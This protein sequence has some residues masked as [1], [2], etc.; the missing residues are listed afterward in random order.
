MDVKTINKLFNIF[1]FIIKI[2]NVRLKI[3]KYL[4]I[5]F[6]WIYLFHLDLNI[7]YIDNVQNF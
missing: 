3:K 2:L 1:V 7:L 4:F 6:T 5:Y